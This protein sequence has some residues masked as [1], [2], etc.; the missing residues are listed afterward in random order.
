MA[1]L[2][3][4]ARKS[5]DEGDHGRALRFGA[6]SASENLI[7]PVAADAEPPLVRAYHYS[8]LLGE[9]RE[10]KFSVYSVAFDA[11]AERLVSGSQDGTVRFLKKTDAGRWVPEQSFIEAEG[12]VMDARFAEDGKAV[13]VRS[14]SGSGVTLWREGGGT[15][16]R[17]GALSQH[18]DSI[19]AF[20]VS[21]ISADADAVERFLEREGE[22]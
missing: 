9:F 21:K 3:A 20:D 12:H 22:G 13:L 16:I 15:W 18:Q 4:L 7:S 11:P 1:V 14:M 2:A 17:Q 6:L 10:H 5:S 8:T 19:R